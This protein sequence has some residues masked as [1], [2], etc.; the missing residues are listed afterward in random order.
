[1][2][3]SESNIQARTRV[4]S[5]KRGWRLWRNNRGVATNPAG[6]PV[7]YG[8]ANDSK[9]LGDVLKS[10]DLIGWRRVIITQDMVGKVIAQV[11]SAECKPEGWTY[12]PKDEREQAQK[13]WIDLV[14]DDGGYALF[15]TDPSKL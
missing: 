3:A 7:R 6:Q 14:N 15:V 9:K 13:R 5:T 1:M 10:S 12:N 4:E 2:S 11:V 8:L